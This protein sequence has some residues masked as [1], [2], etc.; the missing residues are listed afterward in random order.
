VSKFKSNPYL[1]AIDICNEIEWVNQNEECGKIAWDR[2]QY[3]VARTAS[4][5]HDSSEVLVTLGSAAVK[6]NSPKYEGNFWSDANL[7]N[8]YNKSNARLDFYSPH[9]Y[10][11]TVQWFGNFAIDKSPADYGI[12]DRPCVIG[13]NPAKGV[14][15]DGANPKLVVAPSEM[16]IAAYNKGWKGLM[17]WTSNGVDSN[18]NLDNFKDG[19]L[20]FKNAHPK[21]IDPS[22]A[23]GLVPQL[24][25]NRT[26]LLDK[27]YQNPGA[28]QFTIILSD[29]ENVVLQLTDF[30]GKIIYHEK[31]S[32]SN[33]ILPNNKLSNGIYFISAKK[34]GI[35]ETRKIFLN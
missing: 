34:D 4:A 21:L 2:L 7:K 5:V 35:I 23:T 3:L 25:K 20:A 17:P 28:R 8:Q 12:N 11:W 10:G 18:G 13:E 19:L 33:V 30:S 27:V 26:N 32:C 15:N 9:F 14:F 31:V 1:W 16:F 22:L 24:K 29:F 6:W